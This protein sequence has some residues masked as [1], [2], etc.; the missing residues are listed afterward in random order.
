MRIQLYLLFITLLFNLNASSPKREMRA[1]WVTTV[2]N[3]DFPKRP[4]CSP[5]TLK[6]ELNNLLDEHQKDGINAI[7]FQVRPS[8]DALYNSAYEPWSKFLTGKQGR[9]PIG[10]FDPLAYLIKEGH[11]RHMEI[12]AWINPFRARLNSS[13]KLAPWH[14]YAVHPEWGWDYG[15]KSYFDPGI[16]AVREYTKKVVLDIVKRYDIDGI[17]FDDYFYP[18]R[19]SITSPLPDNK[20][21]KRYGGKYY[22]NHIDD[23]RRNNINIFIEEVAE[24]IKEEKKWVKFGVSPFGIWKNSSEPNDGLP[25]KTGTSDYDM[26]Y[27][28]VIKWMKEGWLDYCAPQLYWA[29][30]FKPAD[31]AKLLKW[32]DKH[33][34]GRNIYVGHSL[35]KINHNSHELAWQSYNE[36]VLQINALRKTNNFSG[37]VFYSSKHLLYR[38]DVF[39]LRK[40]LQE[41]LYKNLAL[42]PKMPWIDD[43]SPDPPRTV[44]FV[45]SSRG[46]RIAWEA[47]LY[48][49][50]MNEAYMY[51][52]YKIDDAK[53]QLNAENIITITNNTNY[54]LPLDSKGGIYAVTALDRMRNESEPETIKVEQHK[55]SSVVFRKDKEFEY[56]L[57]LLFEE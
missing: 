9:S 43:K 5:A 42:S 49:D 48:K 18:Y 17:H 56:D 28:D 15:Y 4:G 20:S 36:I 44:Q 46:N 19:K 50:E 25:T 11:K 47:P 10:G 55:L 7:F 52:I 21:F 40:V 57:K 31:Y 6:N 30:G 14:P 13:E 32:W 35:Y 3:I 51:V 12:H 22:P 1:V 53:S 23:W 38:K 29:I 54:Y 2:A 27:A 45:S 8:A 33:S 26:L 41:E 16:P 34:Y 37:S 39:P 24:A